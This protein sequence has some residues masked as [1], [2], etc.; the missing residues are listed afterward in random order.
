MI[1]QTNKKFKWKD[2]W[3]TVCEPKINNLNKR[4]KRKRNIEVLIKKN[5]EDSANSIN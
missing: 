4:G 5:Q 3:V 2:I 1:K